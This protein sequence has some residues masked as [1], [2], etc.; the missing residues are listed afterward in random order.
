[1]K[2]SFTNFVRNVRQ[3]LQR[4]FPDLYK[5]KDGNQRLLRDVRFLKIA[6]NGN[7]PE[8]TANKREKLTELIYQGRN[9]VIKDTGMPEETENFLLQEENKQI[10]LDRFDDSDTSSNG[11]FSL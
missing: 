7:I 5:G 1:M 8:E 4:L 9:K 10:R 2:K 6:C 3:R 11:S